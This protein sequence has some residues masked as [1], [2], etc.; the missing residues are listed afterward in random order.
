MVA[1][2]CRE[3]IGRAKEIRGLPATDTRLTYVVGRCYLAGGDSDRASLLFEQICASPGT[4]QAAGCA[5]LA[6]LEIARNRPDRARAN[7]VR[8]IAA[9]RKSGN[10]YGVTSLRLTLAILDAALRSLA[11]DVI[12]LTKI[13]NDDHLLVLSIE[14]CRVTANL[15]T[16]REIAARLDRR[17]V[18]HATPQVQSLSAIVQSDIAGIE[19]KPSSA[20]SWAKIAAQYDN[21]SY[22]IDRLGQAY[23]AAAM[24]REAIAQFESV[25]SKPNERMESYD[26]PAFHRLIE[27]HRELARLYWT[28]GD[29][30][31]AQSHQAAAARFAN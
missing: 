12:D 21:S 4:K 24:N 26:E 18:A 11:D 2:R 25:L 31:R 6:D 17:R 10:A 15:G 13:E 30:A 9:D 14:L 1:G 28:S 7:L 5:A 29:D 23:A 27:I 8:A 19:N 22:V 20:V 16:L 3:T